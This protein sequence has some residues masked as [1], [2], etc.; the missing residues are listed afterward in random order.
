MSKIAVIVGAGLATRIW[1]ISSVIP[2][3]LVNHGH[4]TMLKSQVELYQSLGADQ[5]IVLVPESSVDLVRAYI[6]QEQLNILVFGIDKAEGSAYAISELSKVY[7]LNDHNVIFNWSDVLPEFSHFKW[8]SDVVYVYGDECRFRFISRMRN[9]GEGG[10]VVGVFQFANFS[11]DTENPLGDLVEVY[12]FSEHFPIELS[13]VVDVGD[14]DKLSK[15]DQTPGR[16]FNSITYGD[17]YVIKSAIGSKGMQLQARESCWYNKFPSDTRHGV[18]PARLIGSNL[19]NIFLERVDGIPLCEAKQ[20][21]IFN[22]V[23]SLLDYIDSQGS[24]DIREGFIESDYKQEFLNKVFE[25][26]ESISGLINQFSHIKTINGVNIHRSHNEL[27]EKVYNK[28]L[29]F[30]PKTYSP[31]HGDLNFSNILKANNDLILI[32]PRG[33]FGNTLTYGPKDYDKAKVLYA[34]SGYD[35]FNKNPSWNG[36]TIRDDKAWIE[37]EP[38]IDVSQLKILESQF[39]YIH[40]LMVAVIWM[41]LAGY[42]KN[43]PYKAL[44]AYF[45]GLYKMR[46]LV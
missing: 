24:I 26:N 14:F 40:Q 11:C 9:V 28:I 42:Y 39:E 5:V 18:R 1:P 44:A 3:V 43:N 2:K 34:L 33:Y 31:I 17:N 8:N 6:E 20:S 45:Y 16:E 21:D 37:I 27:I 29:S 38:L 36:F 12:D 32:D 10:N 15:I 19:P 7:P 35:H 4:N 13:S 23:F 30:I 46:L 41:C 25:R 22:S